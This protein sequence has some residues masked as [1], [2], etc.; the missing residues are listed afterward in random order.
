MYNIELGLYWTATAL[1]ALSFLLMLHFRRRGHVP[2]PG[3]ALRMLQAAAAVHT[4]TISV[5]ALATGRL[6]FI[7]VYESISASC[8]IAVMLLMFLHQL[9]RIPSHHVSASALV[10]A[11]LLLGAGAM[12]DAGN[13]LSANLYST[14]LYIHATAATLS[15]SM[16]LVA[17]IGAASRLRPA[18][19]GVAHTTA[20][21]VRESDVWRLFLAGFLFHSIMLVS[22]ALW[23]DAAWGRYWGWDAVEVG[24]LGVWILVASVFH[25]RGLSIV[26]HRETAPL[27][28]IGASVLAYFMLWVVGSIAPTIH[29]H[30]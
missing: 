19:T 16:F 20:A 17:A 6:P 2:M 26:S 25:I 11:L 18:H 14:W 8:L 21:V 12:M 4:A 22:G 29:I 27:C 24:C 15:K 28:I 9:D 30:G 3:H 7:D 13:P 23:A 1:Y 5:R 10:F